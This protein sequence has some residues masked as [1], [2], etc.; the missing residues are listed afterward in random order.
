[1]KARVKRTNS[2]ETVKV[3]G[4]PEFLIMYGVVLTQTTRVN[5]AAAAYLS[6]DLYTDWAI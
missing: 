6:S 5:T 4:R 2:K 3:T 1:M